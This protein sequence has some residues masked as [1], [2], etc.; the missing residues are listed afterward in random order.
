MKNPVAV[1]K[2]GP[3][4]ARNHMPHEHAQA[5]RA[6]FGIWHMRRHMESCLQIFTFQVNVCSDEM[7]LGFLGWTV[8]QTVGTKCCEG[9]D[10]SSTGP[11]S[12]LHW[13]K[14]LT[15]RTGSPCHPLVTLQSKLNFVNSVHFNSGK[16]SIAICM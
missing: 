5:P 9:E 16:K 1:S 14:T 4:S 3:W 6:M 11:L 12:L 2:R 7:F 13:Q 8:P 15:R 10:R